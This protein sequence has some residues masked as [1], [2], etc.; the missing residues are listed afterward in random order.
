MRRVL[1]AIAI[2]ALGGLIAGATTVAR[3]AL[4]QGPPPPAN[5]VLALSD[6]SEPVVILRDRFGVPHIEARTLEDGFA[7]LGFAHAQDRLWQ[8]DLL[9]RH[10]NGTLSEV[11]GRVTLE[12]DR[13]ART[14]GLADHARREAVKLSPSHRRLLAAYAS[15]VNAWLG[16]VRA[17]RVRAPFEAR[18]LQY[19]IPDWTPE[20]TLAIVRFR[21]WALSR[22]LGASMMLQRLMVELGSGPSRDFFPERSLD[23]DPRLVGSLP[24]LVRIADAWR[25][26]AGLRGPVG[27]LGFVVGK[28]LTGGAPILANDAHFE[29]EIPPAFSLAQL[30]TPE[31]S[32]AGATWPGVPVFWTGHNRRIGWGQVALGASTSDL[33]NETL[34]PTNPDRYDRNGRWLD[35]KLREERIAVRDGEPEV[36]IV[37]TTRHGPLLG[38]ALPDDPT[39]R[40]YALAWAGATARSGVASLLELQRARNWPEFRAA[41]R[42][43]PAPVATFLYA[44]VD[45]N[46]GLQ[47]AGRLPIRTIPTRFL[48]VPGGTRYND[49]R[50]FIPFDELPTRFGDDIKWLVAS[51]HPRQESFSE[52]VAWWWADGRADERLRIRL[53]ESRRLDM[54]G[55]LEIQRER[56]S[57]AAGEPLR[58]LLGRTTGRTGRGEEIRR[59]LLDWDGATDTDSIGATVYHAFRQRLTR[60]LLRDRIEGSLD[61]EAMVA[62]AEPPPGVMMARF[63]ERAGAREGAEL[64]DT[65]LEETWTWL[66]VHVSSNPKKWSWGR[67]HQLRLEHPFERIGGGLLPVL[68]RLLGRG[69]LP[70]P[71]DAD[72]VWA[73]HHGALPAL[74]GVGP[75][76]RLTLDLGDLDHPR[77]GLAGGQS[78]HPGAP[79]YDDALTDW[80]E[81]RPRPLWLH[82]SD[83]AYQTAG[84]WELHPEP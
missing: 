56:R 35:A 19:E 38:S 5:G 23:Q 82:A 4:S 45:E 77:F 73:M 61:L 64:V 13:L 84:R 2:L 62:A 58:A 11:F 9:R 34:H 15:G 49:W 65:A 44:D 78:G 8:M 21:S 52:P 42:D 69:P 26:G 16:E 6:L 33:F 63:L 18:W 43:Y 39:V 22:T 20:D 17:G 37:R 72:S 50:G 54:D 74:A 79:L 83:L 60:S 24:S 10:A 28:P 32:L 31:L 1:I 3:F 81:A 57:A 36:F 12:R 41:L 14:L 29:F 48:P 68:G 67:L 80:L 53:R 7:G 47:V 46:T 55:V 59:I 25:G 71:G 40:S 75:V 76:L 30:R 51:T 27:S 66:G 70:A